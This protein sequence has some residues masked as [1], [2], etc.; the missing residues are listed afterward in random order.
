[1]KKLTNGKG[2][3][4]APLLVDQN[5]V[6][7]KPQLVMGW[8]VGL[9][10]IAQVALITGTISG[11]WHFKGHGVLV[12]LPTYLL[13]LRL[14]YWLIGNEIRGEEQMRNILLRRSFLNDR[15]SMTTQQAMA[16]QAANRVWV[17]KVLMFVG[18]PI[19]A[20]N[21]YMDLTK[22]DVSPWLVGGL[23]IFPLALLTA[24]GLMRGKAWWDD[25]YGDLLVKLQEDA[26]ED[27]DEN[28][29]NMV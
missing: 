1:M 19:I 11:K 14:M 22:Y 20:A 21:I 18:P 13:V 26:G 27:P 24:E 5:S 23:T 17:F 10:M 9:L 25:A 4:H 7:R 15:A 29:L 8:A 16:V 28:D 3:H 2:E 6:P 12:L